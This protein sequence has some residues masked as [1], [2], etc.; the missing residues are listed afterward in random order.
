[1][2][3][4]DAADPAARG[5]TARRHVFSAAIPAL[6]DELGAL[7]RLHER[8]ARALR[9]AFLPLIRTQPEVRLGRIESRAYDQYVAGHQGAPVCFNIIRAEP[10]RGNLIIALAPALVA[11][12]VDGFFGGKART[13]GRGRAEF[14]ATE[15]R[16]IQRL[17]DGM[18]AGL[19][20][21][22]D[23]VA[24]LRF[25]HVGTE[26]NAQLAMLLENDDTVLFCPFVVELD[27]A[28]LAIDLLYPVQMLQPVLPALRSKLGTERAIG[29]PDW[30][31]RMADALLGIPLPLRAVL[32]EP[33]AP[34]GRLIGLSP[35]DTIPI[36]VG[37]AVRLL[38]GEVSVGMGAL[39]EARGLA[40]LRL[41]GGPAPPRATLTAAHDH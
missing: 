2:S 37:E 25:A 4:A 21:A 33:V 29:G 22:W 38:A 14:T 32:A 23:E 3:R 31:A 30:S 9:R 12:L 27:D 6:D 28:E 19:A 40:A 10:L 20:R 36:Q 13:G 8:F 41:T 15:E 26:A 39:G 17:V 24:P 35:G 18:C 5:R 16:V 7:E 11:A 1:M 34:L